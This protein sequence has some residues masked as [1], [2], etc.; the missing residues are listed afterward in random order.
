MWALSLPILMYDGALIHEY[1]PTKEP[2]PQERHQMSELDYR[3]SGST[4]SLRGRRISFL[5]IMDAH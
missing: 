4:E 3:C 2:E 1:S 5:E